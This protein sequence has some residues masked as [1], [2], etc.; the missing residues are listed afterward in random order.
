M[1]LLSYLFPL[2][3]AQLIVAPPSIVLPNSTT[4][5]P[6]YKCLYPVTEISKVSASWNGASNISAPTRAQIATSTSPDQ[7]EF[8]DLSANFVDYNHSL[9]LYCLHIQESAYLSWKTTNIQATS[10]FHCTQKETEGPCDND[11]PYT[12][13]VVP[14]FTPTMKP[15]CCGQCFITA[16][17]AH[18]LFWPTPALQP[19][20]STLVGRHGF[21]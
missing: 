13:T 5:K 9:S 3:A 16:S 14:D 10:T 12:E 21:T 18:A 6:N 15:P 2:S 20:I 7:K 11:G 8:L 19:N 4:G 17:R 1:P